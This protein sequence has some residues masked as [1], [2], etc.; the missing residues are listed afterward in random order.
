M[1]RNTPKAIALGA[2]LRA[3]RE[4]AGI[5][6][7]ML[8]KQL[9]LDQSVV[10]RS[11]SGERVPSQDEVAAILDAVGVTGAERD[12]IIE[13]ARDTSGSPWQGADLPE[14]PVQLA[15]LLD[16]EQM[17]QD[18]VEWSPLVIPGLLQVSSYARA[19][20]RA[21]GVPDGE[22]E[23]R[24]AIRMGR[25]DILTRK[26][27]ARCTALI[28]ES[29]LRQMIGGPEVVVEQLDYLLAMSG[30]RTIDLRVVTTGTDW[31]PGLYGPFVLLTMEGG[32]SVVHLENAR[33]AVFVPDEDDVAVYQS[34]VLELLGIALSP[35]QSTEL[36]RSEAE[37]I[38]RTH[39]SHVAEVDQQRS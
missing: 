1:I 4:T 11:E 5:S 32:V 3:A 13:S 16:V 2:K 17:T 12:E 29:A 25:K 19:I 23:T 30:L 10:S 6:Q 31:H 20:M 18:Y 33:S 9:R 24:V 39:D 38:A 21:A 26:K 14:Q 35:E 34:A 28:G 27:A 36:I 7:R 22:I 37:R 15:A 8:A